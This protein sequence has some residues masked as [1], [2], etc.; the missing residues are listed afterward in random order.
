MTKIEKLKDEL[1]KTYVTHDGDIPDIDKL[2]DMIISCNKEDNIKRKREGLKKLKE[3]GVNKRKFTKEKEGRLF[4]MIYEF[5]YTE[6]GLSLEEEGIYSIFRKH[7]LLDG[8]NMILIKEHYSITSIAK[9]LKIGRH[10][11]AKIAK[12]LE[13]KGMIKIVKN[14]RGCDIY[15]N[16]YYYRVSRWCC[17]ET[18][19][20]FNLSES[21]FE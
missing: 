7:I 17:I 3:L 19:K 8:T 1:E 4:G 5:D 21:L 20:L 12:S 15:I 6:K 13:E 14:G 16:P 18:I 11:L 2:I 9:Y 10:K